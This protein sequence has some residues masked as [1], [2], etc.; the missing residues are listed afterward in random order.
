MARQL[1][2]E[3]AGAIYHVMSRG[4]RREE[5]FLDDEDRRRFLRT[6]GEACERAGWQVHAYCL[7][8]NHFH[9]VLETPQPTLVAGMKWFLGTY[10]QRFNARHGMRGHLFEG[11]YKSLVVD[12]S[13][14]MYLRVVCDYVHLNPAR[15]GLLGAQ[16]GLEDY[17]WSSFPEYLKPPKKR[18]PWLHV[19]RLLGEMGIRRDGALGR[20]EFGDTMAARCGVEGHADEALWSGIRRGWKLGAEDFV[21]RLVGMGV[22]GSGNTGIHAA[23][24]VEETMEQKAQGIA[25]GFLKERGMGVED[26]RKLK[27]GHPNKIA[28]ARELRSKTTMTMAWI[29]KELNAGVPQ[30]LWRALWAN[31]EKSDNTRD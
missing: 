2:I 11:R 30:T 19:D 22:G 15:A 24:A 28:L 4:D 7:M 31:S 20:R 17:A 14:D 26:L 18:V 21:E 6:L 10:T 8:G 5:I 3:Y 9:L 29:A 1:R 25:R 12:G 13:D 23:E 27:K 16:G